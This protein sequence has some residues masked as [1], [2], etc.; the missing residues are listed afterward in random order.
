[1]MKTQF[2]FNDDVIISIIINIIK[3]IYIFKTIDFTIQNTH[4]SLNMYLIVIKRTGKIIKSFCKNSY[5]F[6]CSNED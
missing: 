1:M 3:W 6:I 2:C 5:N 4:S